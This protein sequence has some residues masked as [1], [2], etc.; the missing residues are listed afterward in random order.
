MRK[1]LYAIAFL[2]LVVS[3]SYSQGRTQD[4]VYLKN[5]SIIR[6]LI[7]EQVPNKSIKVQTR[8]E[9][10]FVYQMD[11][12][13]K[14]GKEEDTSYSFKK[15]L[16]PKRTYDIK[17]YRGFLDLGYTT[18]DDGCIQFTTS[19]GYQLNPYFFFGAGTG[20]SYFT[21]SKSAL[22]PVFADLRGNFTNGQIVPFIGLRIGYAIDV[23]SD[24]GGNGFYCNPFVGVKYMLGKQSAVNFSL[25]YGSQARRYSFRGHSSSK[26]IDGFNFKI[27]IE[28]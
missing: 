8:D 22:I 1:I 3:Y 19:H 17:G 25:G 21:D 28:F 10:I 2:F 24:Y 11:E 27:G 7:I 5:G 13:E 6:G 23:T 15:I 9:S 20:V 14:L 12:I 16:G 18:G 4:V 26:S